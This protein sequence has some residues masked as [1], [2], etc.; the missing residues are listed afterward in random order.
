M[1]YTE[2]S[3]FYHRYKVGQKP[4]IIYSFFV[5]LSFPF[6]TFLGIE[7]PQFS[8]IVSYKCNNAY[9]SCLP[10]VFQ[11]M[12]NALQL[13]TQLHNVMYIILRMPH[14]I[15]INIY[16]QNKQKFETRMICFKNIEER[17]KQ[18]CQPFCVFKR[19]GLA[20]ELE[21]PLI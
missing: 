7:V 12:A 17:R 11:A 16:K 2:R 18:S 15:Y 20:D 6:V 3:H 1:L 10:L 13:V 8:F 19:V 9:S 5:L 4:F 21:L 14:C